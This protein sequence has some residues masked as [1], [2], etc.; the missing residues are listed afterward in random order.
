MSVDWSGDRCDTE[1]SDVRGHF[2]AMCG[3]IGAVI[4]LIQN[5]SDVRGHLAAMCP[6]IG[7][8]IGVIQNFR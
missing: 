5:Y 6:W 3:W 1:F 2:A 4:R 8:V 7:A